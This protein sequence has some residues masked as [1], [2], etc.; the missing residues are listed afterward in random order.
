MRVMLLLSD[1][2]VAAVSVVDNGDVLIDIKTV[3]A[4]ALD[5]RK[6]DSA[7]A[8]S[9]MRV[10]VV[11]RLLEAQAW[12]PAGVRMLVIEGYRPPALQE[13]Y[14]AEH[15]AQLL[16]DEPSWSAERAFS[17]ASKHVSPVMTAPHPCGAAVDV[18]LTY[19]GVEVDMGTPVNATP[20]ASGGACF[21]GAT[22]VSADAREW[23]EVLCRS[24]ER[25][26]FVNYPPEWWH[27]SF[28]DRYWAAVS[29]APNAIYGP[30]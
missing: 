16:R 15:L 19:E 10:G 5:E 9:N 4:L 30:V 17:E 1:P 2:S 14:F 3:P 23:R 18:T 24:M 21:T 11:D 29:G 7:G 28:G 27:W 12:L 13:R 22:N 6:K 8:W 20:Q 25:A 26:G